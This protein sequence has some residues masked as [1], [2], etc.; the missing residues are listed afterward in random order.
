MRVICSDSQL[1]VKL[2]RNPPKQRKKC[3]SAW[4]EVI[5]FRLSAVYVIPGSIDFQEKPSNEIL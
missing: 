2:E 5:I 1:F 3:V 4:H